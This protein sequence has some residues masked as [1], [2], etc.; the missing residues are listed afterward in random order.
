M[1]FVY[2]LSTACSWPKKDIALAG[3]TTTL[4]LA[5]WAQTQGITRECREA[6]PIIGTCGEGVSPNVYFPVVTAA[7]IGVAHAV[8]RD[9]RPVFLGAVAG[10]QGTTVYLNYIIE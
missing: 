10:A 3:V 1:L 9:F 7:H 6:N 4:L 2:C 5:D 8:G